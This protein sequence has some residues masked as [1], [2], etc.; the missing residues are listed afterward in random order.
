M[1]FVYN[2]VQIK[3]KCFKKSWE[4]SLQLNH[5]KNFISRQTFHYELVDDCVEV[6]PVV[7]FVVGAVPVAGT[8]AGG[9]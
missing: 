6:G 9:A 2:S 3:N 1:T 8:E 4:Q 5:V 7:V